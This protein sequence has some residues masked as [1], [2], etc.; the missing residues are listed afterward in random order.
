[1]RAG[2]PRITVWDVSV[3]CFLLLLLGK[4]ESGDKSLESPSVAFEAASLGRDSVGG[5]AREVK[6]VN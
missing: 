6:E 1:M 4:R 2:V 5:S 3:L